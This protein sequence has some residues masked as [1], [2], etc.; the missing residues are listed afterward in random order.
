LVNSERAI[1]LE[2]V[3][4]STEELGAPLDSLTA[5]EVLVEIDRILKRKVPVED[6]IR[7]G[8]YQS[9]EQFIE[10]I[11]ERAFKYVSEHP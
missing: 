5:M 4:Q 3:P 2:E 11:S 7:K 1:P 10:E 9:R 6:V 8:G